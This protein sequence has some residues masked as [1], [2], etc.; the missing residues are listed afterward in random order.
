LAISILG[1]KLGNKPTYTHLRNGVWHYWRRVPQEFA[2]VDARV[3]GKQSLKTDSEVVAIKRAAVV[4]DAT[5]Q[6]R[7]VSLLQLPHVQKQKNL[8]AFHTGT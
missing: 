1:N 7:R 3:F 4:N 5:E 8:S 2:H 6:Y